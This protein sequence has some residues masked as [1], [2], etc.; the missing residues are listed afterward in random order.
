VGGTEEKIEA[1]VETETVGT[2][3]LEGVEDKGVGVQTGEV[4]VKVG[5][6]NNG[7]RN[8]EEK[9]EAEDEEGEDKKEVSAMPA[10]ETEVNEGEIAETCKKDDGEALEG[11][12]IVELQCQ[13]IDAHSGENEATKEDQKKEGLDEEEEKKKQKEEEDKKQKEEEEKK[14]KEE[15]E[16]K[17]K[18]E[19]E[20]KKKEEEKKQKEEEGFFSRLF[21]VQKARDDLL[22]PERGPENAGCVGEENMLNGKIENPKTILNSKVPVWFVPVGSSFT[23]YKS[24]ENVLSVTSMVPSRKK[25][26]EQNSLKEWST[27][28]IVYAAEIPYLLHPFLKGHGMMWSHRCTLDTIVYA[29]KGAQDL[30]E[31]CSIL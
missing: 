27:F 12:L 23:F 20:K 10:V 11:E 4:A 6:E 3:K 19:E 25:H 29:L 9:G 24:A 2:K 17:Q 1:I 7:V 21:N 28:S 31:S 26:L 8:S 18:E 30:C 22:E 16:K 13:D 5:N 14:A 15:E